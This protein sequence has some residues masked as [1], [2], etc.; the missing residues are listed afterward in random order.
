[1]TFVFVSYNFVLLT[2]NSKFRFHT[3]I[4][5]FWYFEH[6]I[7]SAIIYCIKRYVKPKGNLDTFTYN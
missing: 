3:G 2:E 5:V 6:L 1:M 4:F 7:G